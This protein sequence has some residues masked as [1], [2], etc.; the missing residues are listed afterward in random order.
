MRRILCALLMLMLLLLRR[1]RHACLLSSYVVC[2]VPLLANR[3]PDR[4]DDGW[5][6]ADDDNVRLEAATRHYDVDAETRQVK[7]GTD[8][9]NTVM[10][11]TAA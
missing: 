4:A 1:R 6:H 7:H 9:R 8:D 2:V 11:A 10:A 5:A 3:G